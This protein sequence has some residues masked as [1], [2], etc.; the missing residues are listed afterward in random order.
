MYTPHQRFR[1]NPFSISGVSRCHHLPAAEIPP[2]SLINFIISR[3]FQ[4][5]PQIINKRIRE[6]NSSNYRPAHQCRP[7]AEARTL[8]G[9]RA[10]QM[11]D[12]MENTNCAL[13]VRVACVYTC[14]YTCVNV[15]VCVFC[16]NEYVCIWTHA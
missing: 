3:H 1:Q 15:C 14:T 12:F 9:A 10:N 4:R 2:R 16:Q 13:Y 6:M 5:A 7:A 8:S 11:M